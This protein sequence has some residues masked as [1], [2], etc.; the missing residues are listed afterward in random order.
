S[1]RIFIEHA[2]VD[3]D[4]RTDAECY[5]HNRALV[6]HVET[7]EAK[8]R[9]R[10]LLAEPEKRFNFYDSRVPQDVYNGPLFDKWRK[11][12]ERGRP[13][14]LFMHPRDLLKRS[15]DDVTPEK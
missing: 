1:R 2:L 4:F 11:Y 3:G 14:L 13:T 7:L 15:A 9:R 8:V 10:D 5:K 12:V 6:K